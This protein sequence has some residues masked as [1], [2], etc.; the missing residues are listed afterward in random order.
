MENRELQNQADRLCA[1]FDERYHAFLSRIL[2]SVVDMEGKPDSVWDRPLSESSPTGD[3]V[4]VV[5]PPPQY[6]ETV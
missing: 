2:N 4:R 5:C 1:G 3:D 6:E